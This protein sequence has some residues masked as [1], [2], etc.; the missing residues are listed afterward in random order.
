MSDVTPYPREAA[1]REAGAEPGGPG[2]AYASWGS[3][4]GAYLLDVLILVVPLVLAVVLIFVLASDDGDESTEESLLLG[5]YLLTLVLPFLY[6]TLMHGGE[7][8]ATYGKRALG[9]RVVREDG[10]RLGYGKAFGRYGIQF[11]L[12][13]LTLPLIV[14]YLWP[15]WD[16]RKQSLHDK[17]VRSIV[18]R[19]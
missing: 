16:G 15:L 13:I 6:F 5:L 10:S 18:V 7:R 2:H 1:E 11:L 19:A 17:A 4:V 9:I 12:G 14:D 8:G 3:R